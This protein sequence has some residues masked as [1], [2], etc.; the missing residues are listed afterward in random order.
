VSVASPC[1]NVCRLDPA[2]GWCQGCARTIDE[3]ARWSQLTEVQRADVWR[4]L[5]QRRIAL[6][7]RKVEPNPPAPPPQAGE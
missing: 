7:L 1:I 6:G 2:T 3:I 5:P 4:L